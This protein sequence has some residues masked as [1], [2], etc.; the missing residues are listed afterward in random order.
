MIN[1]LNKV[2]FWSLLT[3]VDYL[4][5]FWPPVRSICRFWVRTTTWVAL[6]YFHWQHEAFLPGCLFLDDFDLVYLLRN[7]K[8]SKSLHKKKS[9]N[10]RMFVQILLQDCNSPT[11]WDKFPLHFCWTK[12]MR[13][14]NMHTNHLHIIG[15]L[16]AKSRLYKNASITEIHF[17]PLHDED[18]A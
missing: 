4:K 2:R 7:S 13:K 8:T 5:P 11:P 17:I 18:D 3:L 15:H 16:E 12:C 1:H 10:F 9:W 6:T 14:L